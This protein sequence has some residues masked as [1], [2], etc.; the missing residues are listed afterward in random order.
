[1]SETG[2]GENPVDPKYSPRGWV[3]KNENTENVEITPSSPRAG[4]GEGGIEGWLIS[5]E[6]EGMIG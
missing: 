3:V 1:M 2:K 4:R 6:N 5:G